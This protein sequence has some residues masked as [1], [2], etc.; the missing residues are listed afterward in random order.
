[1]DFHY[2]GANGYFYFVQVLDT[3]S[4][5]MTG[6]VLHRAQ[7][8]RV[9][10]RLDAES[11]EWIR[12]HWEFH[13]GFV[14][15]FPPPPA[16]DSAGAPAPVETVEPFRIRRIPELAETPEDLARLE[17]DP[18]AMNYPQLRSYVDQVRASGGN[19]DDYVVDMYTKISYPWTSFVLAVL[20]V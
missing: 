11:G 14:R 12:D 1:T 20:G 4:Q 18:D 6:I 5:R 15:T 3:R 2:R 8:G 9:V 16:A 13:D 17:P 19:P 7:R 10:S